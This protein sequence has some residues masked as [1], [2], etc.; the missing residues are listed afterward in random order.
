MFTGCVFVDISFES[1]SMQLWATNVILWC[2]PF[3]A[4]LSWSKKRDKKIL[5]SSGITTRFITA[6]VPVLINPF[7]Y[8]CIYCP[9]STP[10]SMVASLTS[11]LP[12]VIFSRIKGSWKVIYGLTRVER[13][14]RQRCDI[15]TIT[16]SPMTDINLWRLVHAFW[17]S[18]TSIIFDPSSN[19]RS[20]VDF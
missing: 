3:S 19:S 14:M 20:S 10:G 4:F 5:I 18:Y 6:N 9:N 15:W 12:L 8:S 13:N 11:F 7:S 16:V 1:W 17:S 2:V